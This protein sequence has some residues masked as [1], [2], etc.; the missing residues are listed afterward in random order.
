MT[1]AAIT[2]VGRAPG[3]ARC[4]PETDY[5]VGYIGGIYI[6]GSPSGV[7]IHTAPTP[8]SYCPRLPTAYEQYIHFVEE[9]V[10]YPAIETGNDDYNYEKH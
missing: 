4:R 6:T 3:K 9:P 10:L 1:C 7:I 2:V 8:P 5:V